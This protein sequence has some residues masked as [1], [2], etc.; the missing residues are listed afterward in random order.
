VFGLIEFITDFL[1][2]G[3]RTMSLG[4]RVAWL[5]GWVMV[6]VVALAIMWAITLLA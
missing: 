6:I 5:L 1:L 3:G 4:R 2:G